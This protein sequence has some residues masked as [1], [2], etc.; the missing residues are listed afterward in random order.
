M[1]T[2]VFEDDMYLIEFVT[3]LINN[4]YCVR[5]YK[6]KHVPKDADEEPSYSESPAIVEVAYNHAE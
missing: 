2:Y 4:G 1:K 6:N 3:Q 5:I